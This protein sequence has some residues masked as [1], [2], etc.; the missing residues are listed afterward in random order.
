[1]LSASFRFGP[2][3]AHEFTAE[4]DLIGGER[5]FVDGILISKRWSLSPTGTREFEANGHRVRIVLRSSGK[6]V[7]SEAYVDG[8]LKVNEL[9]PQFAR[10]QKGSWPAVARAILWLLLA[11][12]SF[13]AARSLLS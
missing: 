10:V 5:Y 9:F 8:E 12:V 13:V 11:A 3:D 4:C 1:M 2:N 6:E 7:L